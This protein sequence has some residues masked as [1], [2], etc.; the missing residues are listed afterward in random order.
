MSSASPALGP[1]SAAD[2]VVA[3]LL[4]ELAN[5]LQAGEPVDVEAVVREHPE[6]AEQLRRLLPAVQLLAELGRS[7][8]QEGT[9]SVETAAD[10]AG[11]LGDFRLGREIG[12]GGMGVVYEAVQLSLNR[13]VAVKVLPFAATLDPKQLQR[14]KNEAQA[15]AGLHHTN[16]VPVYFVGCERGTHFYAMQLIEGRTLAALI[17]DLRAGE[18]PG[19]QADPQRTSPYTPA[20]GAPDTPLGQVLST[21]RSRRG[22]AFFRTVAR[23]GVQAAE[24][25]EHAHQ[26]GVIHRDI[27][28]GNLL[29]DGRGNLWI[30]DFGL[31]HCQSQAGLTLTGDLVGTLRYM[32]PEQA[33]AQRVVIDH[34]TDVYALGATLYELLTLEPAITGR[35]REEVLRQIAF[36]EP[37]PPRRLN[38]AIPREL[39]T[40]VLKAMEKNP[41]E[42]YA[43]AQE[44]ADDL[45]RFLKDESIRARRPSLVQRA[46]KLA[47][48]HKA[49]TRALACVAGLCL[50]AL[51]AFGYDI[52]HRSARVEVSLSRARDCMA[53]DQVGQARQQLAQARSWIGTY[54]LLL[55][56]RAAQV[57]AFESEVDKLELF[58]TL[59]DQAHEAETAPVVELVLTAE[60]RSGKSAALE[61]PRRYGRNPAKAVPIVRQ[62]LSCYRVLEQDDWSARL[63][64]D[65]LGPDQVARVRR[66]VY[67]ELLWLA[68]DVTLRKV[69]HRSGREVGP[70]AAARQGLAY[71]R[72]AEAAVQP[73]RAFYELRA[74]CRDLLGDNAAAKKD[75]ARAGRMGASIALDHYLL[76]LAAYDAKNKAEGVKEFEAAL[77]LEPTHYWSLMWLGYCLRDLGEQEQELAAAA[78]AFTGCILKRP[79]H[80]H[81]YYCRGVAYFWL[82]RTKE[83]LADY[84]KAIA[85]DPKHA[86]AHTDM[87]TALHDKKDVKGAIAYWRKAIELSPKWAPAHNN[88]GNALKAK[89]DVEGAIACYHKAIAADP[90]FAPAHYNLGNALYAKKDVEGAI[91]CYRKAIAADPKFAPA[92]NR[93]GTALQDKKDLKGAMACFRK[94]IELSPKWAPAHN[95]LG[96]ALKAKGDVEGAIARFRKAI[97]LGPKLASAHN[98]LGLA[99]YAQKDV[100]GAIACFRMAIDIDPKLAQAHSNLGAILCDVKRDYDGAIAR[101]R[102]A[103]ALNHKNADAHTNL[104]NALKGKGDLEGAIE[105]YRKAIEV[106]PNFAYAYNGL[107]NALCNKGQVGAAIAS[108]K[109]AIELAP[110]NA[111]AYSGLGAILC[112]VKR[113][114][115]GAIACFRKAITF[116]PKYAE[117]HYNL[118]IA[119]R[120]QGKFVEAVGAFREA[121][122]LKPDDPEAYNILGTTLAA[123]G[124]LVEAVGAFRRPSG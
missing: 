54:G 88:L 5:R 90:K 107:G 122:R 31:A 22:P 44:L 104:G 61:Q 51:A 87:G 39:E 99:L 120:K 118:G 111:V 86:P 81:A 19:D 62:A 2:P 72:N 70:E 116:N 27:K 117:A 101:F 94:A 12:R 14:F 23:L 20:A 13:R 93:L 8:A 103:I 28:P 124:K 15:A 50:L 9:P 83:A 64:G 38:K 6:R 11:L 71:L 52:Q 60:S 29:V 97:E 82:K 75:R 105:C 110:K 1:G 69:E 77:W 65:W 40:I 4:E 112:D 34:R 7:A 45:E 41:A 92:H 35:D 108:Y 95:N 100:E 17:H 68:E 67:E 47:R 106:D 80:A 32:S 84:A 26:L 91:A 89:G 56:G 57:K 113:D 98:N 85:L 96:L 63:E 21:E 48:R 109:K 121:V 46:R 119:L 76:G 55:A 37:R 114:Y 24:A 30:T 25:L 78:T 66:M 16:I 49:A 42:R 3:E 33:L 74:R 53:N 58:L 79:K 59:L 73:T 36:E 10:A 18:E 123:Q 115:D 102:Q 43:T